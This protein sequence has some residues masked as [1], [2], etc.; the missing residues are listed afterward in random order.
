MIQINNILIDFFESE[1]IYKNLRC[2]KIFQSEKLNVTLYKLPFQPL[3]KPVLGM[4]Q[5][6]GAILTSSEDNYPIVI[7]KKQNKIRD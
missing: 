7:E 3:Q 5:T 2:K 6:G 1:P 4:L